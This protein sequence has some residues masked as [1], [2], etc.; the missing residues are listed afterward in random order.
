MT[1]AITLAVDAMSGDRGHGVAVA[2]ALSCLEADP[3]LSIQ[4]V[5]DPGRLDAALANADRQRLQIVAAASVV[6]MNDVPSRALRRHKQSSMRIALNLVRE[7][8]AQAA[9]SAGNTGA[10]MSMAH[11]VLRPL[12]GIA[13][14]AFVSRIPSAVGLPYMLDLGANAHSSARH[15]AQFALM[16]SALVTATRGIAE[17]TVALLNIGEEDI[18]G[19]E[20]LRDAA[21]LIRAMGLNYVGYIEGD[22]VFL[23]PIDV[24]VCDG[25]TGNVALKTGEGVAQLIRVF[26][27]EEFTRSLATRIAGVLAR[28]VL[29]ALAR[30]VDPRRYNG[31]SLLGLKGVVIKSHGGS[32]EFAFSRAIQ[33]AAEEVRQDVQGRIAKLIAAA[34][35]RG[36]QA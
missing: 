20:A 36:G 11:Y 23:K 15:L 31:A 9:V 26:M 14:P 35:Q 13:R 7:G 3:L 27:R 33:M 4:L 12:P 28:P 10:L 8:Q 19:G 32:D 18:K 34:S 21:R 22:G 6:G 1:G 30:R 2:A 29:S 24:V 5:G 25:F 16:G 17:P